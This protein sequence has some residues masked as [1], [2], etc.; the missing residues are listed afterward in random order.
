MKFFN[1]R[2]KSSNVKED[3]KESYSKNLSQQSLFKAS[4]HVI[5]FKD[6]FYEEREKFE[7]PNMTLYEVARA[8]ASDSYISESLNKYKEKIFKAGYRLEGEEELVSYLSRRI[9]L[10][11]HMN[12]T[13]F[14]ILLQEVADDLITFQNAYLLKLRVDEIPFIKAKAFNG[15]KVVGGY[16]RLDPCDI[17]IVKDKYNNVIRYEIERMGDY[18]NVKLNKDD[19]VHFYMNRKGQDKQ[20]TP[21]LEPVLEDVKALRDIEGDVLTLIHRFCFPMYHIKVGLPQAGY[22]GT[23]TEIEDLRYVIENMTEDGMLL[24]NEKVDIKT[25]GAEGNALDMKEYLSYFEKRIFSG[26]NTSES[27][28]GREKSASPDTVEAQIH[29]SVKHIQRAMSLFVQHYIFNELLLEGGYNPVLDEEHVVKMVFNEISLDTRIKLENHEALKYQ[30]NIQTL[31]ETRTAIGKTHKP[32]TKDL[33]VDNVTNYQAGIQTKQK[34][35]GSIE[36][37]KA[38]A[39]INNSDHNDSKKVVVDKDN[40]KHN[41]S[42]AV[43]TLNQPQNQHGL[44]SVKLKESLDKIALNQEKSKELIEK[45]HKIYKRLGNENFE[46]VKSDQ[47]LLIETVFKAVISLNIFDIKQDMTA[48][49]EFYYKEIQKAFEKLYKE[50]NQDNLD[51][52]AY[53]MRFIIEYWSQKYLWHCYCLMSKEKGIHYLYVNFH[54][55]KEA[56]EHESKINLDFIVKNPK[57]AIKLLPPFHPFCQCELT[58]KYIPPLNNKKGEKK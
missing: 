4:A 19:V 24:T 58:E 30:S 53:R 26:L 22:Q 3:L 27:Q 31:H 45:C 15:D 17:I 23:A 33:Y 32:D 6:R 13:I 21:R 43:A 39:K 49:N 9:A 52:K 54:S 25:I 46:K 37:A 36:L 5:K 8:V 7:Y 18:G 56:K 34:T 40:K 55:E 20:G 11:S 28:M 41:E 47:T 57:K 42:H 50:L 14:D 12:E 10:M 2:Q 35:Q 48:L 16:M 1:F 29:D 51:T 44:Y 38:N